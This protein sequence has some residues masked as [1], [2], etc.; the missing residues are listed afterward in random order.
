M[1]VTITSKNF[2]V[3]P[4]YQGV[5][6]TV[7]YRTGTYRT[8]PDL[9]GGGDLLALVAHQANLFPHFRGHRALSTVQ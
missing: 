1:L 6:G 2:T 5:L 4:P 8:R 9:V 7:R 3:N